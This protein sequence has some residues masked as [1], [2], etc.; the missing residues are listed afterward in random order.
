MR[1]TTYIIMTITFLLSGALSAARI[2]PKA[3]DDGN[4]TVQDI[5]NGKKAEIFSAAK[6]KLV[7]VK[8]DNSCGSGFVM[9]MEDGNKFF[10][11]NKHVVD[12]EKR[13]DAILLNGTKLTLGQFEIATNRDLV[14]FSLPKN[15]PALSA[16]DGEPNLGDRAYVF[17]NSDG[18][19]VATDLAG[20]VTGVGP[21]TIEV[22]ARFI[23]G[24]SGSAVLNDNGKVIGVATYAIQDTSP[25]DWTKKDSRFSDIR[26][27]AVRFAGVKWQAM[28]YQS[29]YKK[30][31]DT[32]NDKKK[33]AGI[34]PQISARFSTPKMQIQGV[35]GSP[36]MRWGSNVEL[37]MWNI[38][39][40]APDAVK[41]PVV[42]VCVLVSGA[43]GYYL[44]TCI[45]T[46]PQGFGRAPRNTIEVYSQ[47]S[48]PVYQ[49]GEQSTDYVWPIGNNRSVY[50]LEGLSYYQMP[51]PAKAS[52]KGIKYWCGTDYRKNPIN[53]NVDEKLVCYRFECWQNGS[54]AGSYDSLNPTLL[55]AKRLP[56]DWFVVGKYPDM[57]IYSP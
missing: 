11:T 44:R 6:D 13:I 17:G 1:N 27:F 55:N 3:N 38:P 23:Q 47:E 34:Y 46:K 43:S 33:K 7:I 50:Y 57:I 56:V 16:E 20:H 4:N 10:L 41:N 48:P 15:T 42:R 53:L 19:G 30:C 14:R 26:R 52:R 31:F 36:V 32:A 51:F 28:S 5:D 2:N 9:E 18:Q 49:Y 29:F 35:V 12:G 37:G 8:G 54:L 39:G 24:N 22:D 45:M 21:E 40:N 25:E